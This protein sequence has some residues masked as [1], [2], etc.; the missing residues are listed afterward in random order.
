[1]SIESSRSLHQRIGIGVGYSFWTLVASFLVPS[2]V[3]YGVLVTLVQVGLLKV[4]ILSQ[5]QATVVLFAVQYML[6]LATLLILPVFVQK[7]PKSKL[8]EIFGV[9]RGPKWSDFGYA[10]LSFAGYIV[11]ATIILT[12]IKWLVPALN[13]EQA[14]DVGFKE[15]T[16]ATGLIAAFVALVVLAPIAEELIFR[17][18]LFGTLRRISGLV[19]A[20][21]VTSILFGVVHGQWNVGIDVAILSAFLCLL[22][23]HTDSVWSGIFLHMTKNFLAYFL[24]FVA[25]LLG[26]QVQ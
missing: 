14:Q 26:I 6:G 2:L 20:I 12:V 25:P 5:P 10:L 1:M 9:T 17:G 11:A 18:Y 7:W 15:L 19:V 22:R 24:L 13:L 23:V 4:D 3:M 21:V 8:R 16:D